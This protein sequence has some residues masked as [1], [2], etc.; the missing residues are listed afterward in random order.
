MR[1]TAASMV[2][3]EGLRGSCHHTIR[4]YAMSMTGNA[5]YAS[6]YFFRLSCPALSLRR[7]NLQSENYIFWGPHLFFSPGFFPSVRRERSGGLL[8][9]GCDRACYLCRHISEMIS[10]ILDSME[11]LLTAGRRL[12]VFFG[13]A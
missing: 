12:T 11:S 6:A 2:A 10:G 3:T 8:H 4:L 13:C 7:G 5:Y 9:S 1:Y